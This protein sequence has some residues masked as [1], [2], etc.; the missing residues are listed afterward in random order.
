MTD[1]KP[2]AVVTG[3]SSGIGHE[4]AKQFAE[5]GF[6]LLICAEDVGLAAAA[7]GLRAGGADVQTVQSDL[8]T[9]DGVE[10]LYAAIAQTGRPVSAAALNA[11]VGQ[12]GA[13][14]ETVLA[15]ELK[16][17]ALNVTS[18][19]HLAKRLLTDMA[20][21]DDGRIL[22][23]SSIAATMPGSFQAVYNASKSFLQSFAEALQN[24]LKDTGITITSLLPGPTETNFF[25]RA[26]MKDT[27]VGSSPKDDPA[28]VAQQGFEALMSGR[29]KIIAGSVK[30]KVQGVANKVLP[31]KL[32]AAVHRRMAEPGSGS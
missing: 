2:L 22:I 21:L 5:H 3:A 30:T 6:D 12:G 25:H 1:T 14:L 9:Y 15:D 28:A 32:K 31:D 17:I 26:D 11:G 20:A 19:V 18:T 7:D 23:T 13:V 10:Q 4:L 27:K 24:E 16:I 8:S 29:D